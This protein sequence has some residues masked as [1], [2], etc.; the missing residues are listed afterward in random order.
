MQSV[1][2]ITTSVDL[3]LALLALPAKES[4]N[5][6]KQDELTDF[7][8]A[9]HKSFTYRHLPD[10]F[11]MRD[12]VKRFK[13]KPGEILDLAIEKTIERI[14]KEQHTSSC[15]EDYLVEAV[16][17]ASAIDAIDNESEKENLTQ[18]LIERT[19]NHIA[20]KDSP[21]KIIASLLLRLKDERSLWI[22]YVRVLRISQ[23]IL[24]DIFG[25]H[26]PQLA[27]ELE[28]HDI[29]ALELRKKTEPP[30]DL[31]SVLLLFHCLVSPQKLERTELVMTL[32]AVLWK[33]FL[34]G[35][36]KPLAL[37]VQTSDGSI[38]TVNL[39][40]LSLAI[41]LNDTAYLLALLFSNVA[42]DEQDDQGYSAAHFAA[43]FG[44]WRSLQIL[45]K[46]GASF[47]LRTKTGHTVYDLLK[48]QGYGRNSP[49][50][51]SSSA[52]FA[53]WS[54]KI[55][56]SRPA[57]LDPIERSVVETA[58]K[59]TQDSSLVYLK[60]GVIHAK[61]NITAG[62]YIMERVGPI[63]TCEE[64]PPAKNQNSL[65]E[66]FP[67]VYL[68]SDGSLLQGPPNC[69][70]VSLMLNGTLR[71]FVYALREIDKDEPLLLNKGF[72]VPSDIK[73]SD[74][75]TFIQETRQLTFFMRVL[76]KEKK[77]M[78]VRAVR[79]VN[80]EWMRQDIVLLNADEKAARLAI[81]HQ[82]AM[83][84]YLY[85]C[86]EA[87]YKEVERGTLKPGRLFSFFSVVKELSEPSLFDDDAYVEKITHLLQIASITPSKRK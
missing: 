43:I 20:A 32:Q 37:R 63:I 33:D 56:N 22:N 45:H 46:M 42:I 44:S 59:A 87:L 9:Q 12:R 49:A 85:Q 76:E 61:R 60:E 65:W 47:V 71:L 79:L 13:N 62:S 25:T 30:Y 29:N 28:L 58:L 39:A 57:D 75:P 34:R 7:F 6:K 27:L 83:M 80:Q 19:E 35:N 52:L 55:K 40:R 78:I 36:T 48:M 26:A 14:T 50:S 86:P 69:S 24:A 70:A 11:F 74:I 16:P 18:R 41:L 54:L 21:F 77:N 8:C 2:L 64:A 15:D 1:P 17:L 73:S 23:H 68:I 31:N 3:E 53:L 72:K 84:R 82:R 66:L 10:L 5:T 81:E 67:G 4:A 38:E 51:Y